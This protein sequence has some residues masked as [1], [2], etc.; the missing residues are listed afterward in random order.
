M[1]IHNE[2]I[3]SD[4]ISSMLTNQITTERNSVTAARVL[5]AKGVWSIN[6]IRVTF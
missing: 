4:Q 2:Q 6:I 5:I 3:D 1:E